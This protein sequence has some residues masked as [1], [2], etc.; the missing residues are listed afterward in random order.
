MRNEAREGGS[1]LAFGGVGGGEA[2]LERGAGGFGA[3]SGAVEG[4]G[5]GVPE[6]GLA[7]EDGNG[8]LVGVDG[9]LPLF[10]FGGFEAEEEPGLGVLG[11][12]GDGEAEEGFEGLAGVAEEHGGLEVGRGGGVVGGDGIIKIL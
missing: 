12:F 8:A 2:A 11:I 4:H 3:A 1:H 9:V 7:G 6:V 5:H 10:A